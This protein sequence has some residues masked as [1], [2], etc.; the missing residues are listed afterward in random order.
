[1]NT[2]VVNHYVAKPVDGMGNRHYVLTREL[3]RRGYDV[4]II[5]SSF[6]H[7][8]RTEAHLSEGEKWRKQVEEGV[9]F[10]WVCTPPYNGIV[11]SRAE[12]HI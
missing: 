8:T 1:M 4:T 6:A 12:S 9:P 10:A 11:P 7:G 3:I 2:L 5:S